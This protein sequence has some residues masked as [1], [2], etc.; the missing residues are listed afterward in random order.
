MDKLMPSPVL[1]I[2][3][4]G[5]VGG[6]LLNHLH[7]LE[8]ETIATKLPGE[9]IKAFSDQ[10]VDLDILDANAVLETVRRFRPAAIIHLAAQ[11]SVSRSWS[12]MDL[13]VD[14]NVKGTIHVL[15]AVRQV[16]PNTR[17]V[18]IG[19][20]EEYG[21]ICH[22]EPVKETNIL[23]PN[24]PYAVS[25]AAQTMFGQMYFRAYGIDVIVMRAFNHIGAGQAPGF[26]V[27]DFCR[28]IVR[29]ERNLAEPI[30]HVG[31]LEA[32]RDFSDVRDIVRGYALV[33]EN[34]KSGSIYNIGSGHSVSID[35]ILRKLM[36]LSHVS[37]TIMPE[38]D[39][40]RPSET[41]VLE[42]DV[43]QLQLDTGYIPEISLEESLRSA[44]EFERLNLSEG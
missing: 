28:Q 11:S 20:S 14:I 23:H 7:V 3:A 32:K 1:I 6:H 30:I 25:K 2:G 15:E 26:V 4:A 13:T 8:V 39:R 40:M 41:P 42:A 12:Q 17:V 33:L 43:Q 36:E 35:T 44:L 21:P 5:F 24:N 18:L 29:I 34:G 22:Q 16:S 19:S 9:S 31:N 10:C 27:P 38:K 37:I